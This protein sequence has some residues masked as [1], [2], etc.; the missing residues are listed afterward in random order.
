MEQSLVGAQLGLED[1]WV[2]VDVLD[3]I[4]PIAIAGRGEELAVRMIPEGLGS[5]GL[6]SAGLGDVARQL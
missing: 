4:E 3:E 1:G 6:G 5:V 2:A